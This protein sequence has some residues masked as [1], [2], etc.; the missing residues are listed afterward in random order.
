MKKSVDQVTVE[1][2]F[3]LMRAD[4]NVPLDEQGR[5]TDDRRI[6]Q[7]LPTVRDILQ[8]DGRLILMSHLG[9]PKGQPDQRYS[10][11]PVA[12]RLG[13][14]I[15][16]PVPLV[17]NYLG[18]DK[19]EVITALRK[20]KVVLLENLRFHDEET[21]KGKDADKDPAVKIRKRQFARKIADLAEVYV[22]DAFGTCHRDN[23]SM[24]TVPLLMEDHPRVVGFLVQ[25]E[26]Q[27]LGDALR[28]PTRPFV[29]VLGGA[30]VSDKIGVIEALL[31]K[32]DA[33]L[34]GGAMA[35]TFMLAPKR[36]GRRQPRRT[37][38]ARPGRAPHGAGRR[39]TQAAGRYRRRPGARP[40]RRHRGI[41]GRHQAGLPRAGH[42]T[43]DHL[44]LLGRARHR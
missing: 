17:G 13:E 18:E 12:T 21:I 31:P 33:I 5:I 38:Q 39:E 15:G 37:R 11:Q 25:K 1:G 2:K 7:A 14:L 27:F 20:G 8:R 22:N 29:C 28:S 36:G 3:V 24:V 9:R 26:L 41:R 10:L 34:I 35:F 43:A 19:P 42:R 16:Q 23:A 40:R 32:C 4:F 44:G 6:V 30:K